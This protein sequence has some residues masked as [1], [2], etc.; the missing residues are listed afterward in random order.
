MNQVEKKIMSV[1]LF[2]LAASSLLYASDSSAQSIGGIKLQ[3]DV[4]GRC[5]DSNYEGRV[6]TL[7]CNGG[8]FQKW[9]TTKPNSTS[10][11]YVIT[12]VETGRCLDSNAQG[13]AYAIPCNGGSYQ[14]WSL[15]LRSNGRM[16][17]VNLATGRYLDSNAQGDVY[18]L[19]FNAG[20]YQLWY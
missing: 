4:T 2:A 10:S 16:Q 9:R 19:P 11:Q 20:R 13:N 7:A 17:F 18:T 8:P 12:N 14:K 1:A 5:L 15:I 6:Y 3:N